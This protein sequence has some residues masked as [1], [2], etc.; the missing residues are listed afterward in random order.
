[1]LSGSEVMNLESF[2]MTG[3]PDN[4]RH[5]EDRIYSIAN[6][7]REIERHHMLRFVVTVVQTDNKFLNIP[8][9]EAFE[10]V[11]YDQ[12]GICLGTG[13]TTPYGYFFDMERPHPDESV[14][15][16]MGPEDFK[17][18]HLVRSAPAFLLREMAIRSRF[19]RL[20]K[21]MA[22]A[23]ANGYKFGFKDDRAK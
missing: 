16:L 23:E 21:F 4:Q 8:E 3:W 15:H 1:M 18:V 9:T 10:L 14:F 20:R 7:R 13:Y 2:S 22:I 19:S 6:L 11:A 5:L 17:P 12:P